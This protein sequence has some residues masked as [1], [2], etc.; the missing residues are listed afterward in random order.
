MERKNYLCLHVLSVKL[1]K[2]YFVEILVRKKIGR[3][4][5]FVTC[6]QQ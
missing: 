1:K 4:V 6:F 5:I 3:A 2:T